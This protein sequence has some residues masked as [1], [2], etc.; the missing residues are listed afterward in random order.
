VAEGSGRSGPLAPAGRSWA[1]GRWDARCVGA[2]LCATY[3]LGRN[4]GRSGRC[5]GFS[6]RRA[7]LKQGKSVRCGVG[8]AS[9]TRLGRARSRKLP[10]RAC[11]AAYVSRPWPCLHRPGRLYLAKGL[12]GRSGRG[13]AAASIVPAR[14]WLSR[15][16]PRLALCDDRSRATAAKRAPS[17]WVAGPTKPS[18]GVGEISKK[19]RYGAPGKRLCCLGVAR[20]NHL[21][22]SMGANDPPIAR[23]WRQKSAARRRSTPSSWKR[24][25]AGEGNQK[26]QDCTNLGPYWR[27]G[28]YPRRGRNMTTNESVCWTARALLIRRQT[29][30]MGGYGLSSLPGVP[31]GTSIKNS[32]QGSKDNRW[33]NR[34]QL[35]RPTK[36]ETRGSN[37][38]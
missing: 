20:A 14:H 25:S 24:L 38:N 26:A 37:H 30:S 1:E 7:F 6:M 33:A 8:A 21:F 27:T 11:S 18:Y 28:R 35:L 3:A 29:S 13:W 15:P 17:P 31:A 36:N 16:S 19:K 12:D 10:D 23:G 5:A 32:G 2:T 9:N 34:R 4:P 22:R